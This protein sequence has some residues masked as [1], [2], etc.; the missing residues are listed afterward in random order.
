MRAKAGEQGDPTSVW[1]CRTSRMAQKTH[2]HSDFASSLPSTEVQCTVRMYEK[3]VFTPNLTWPDGDRFVDREVSLARAASQTVRSY[4][5]RVWESDSS[6]QTK[7]LW[8]RQQII[9]NDPDRKQRRKF[10][11]SIFEW[12]I[13]GSR[14]DQV[15]ARCS[16][17]YCFA[18]LVR[19]RSKF[20]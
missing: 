6:Q 4:N 12:L 11:R 14:K 18:M 20:G 19:M 9:H 13:G 2:R 5:L 17:R 7:I 1:R 8:L 16:L 10:P 3:N 15:E